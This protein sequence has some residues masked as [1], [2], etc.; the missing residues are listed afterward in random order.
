[1]EEEKS[2]NVKAWQFNVVILLLALLIGVTM[3]QI[4]YNRP[5][6]A[7]WQYMVASPPTRNSA[8]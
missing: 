1:M 3:F 6:E 7:N 5:V 4:F 2:L 8:R